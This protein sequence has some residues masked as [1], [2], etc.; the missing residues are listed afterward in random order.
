MAQAPALEPFRFTREQYDRMVDAGVLADLPVELLDGVIVEMTPQ[1]DEHV[2]VIQVLT[3]VLAPVAADFRLRV[4]GPVP[5]GQWSKPEPDL[6][7]VG[8]PG[9]AW[10]TADVVIEVVVTQRRQARV[11]ERIYAA[12]AIPE[13]WVVDVPARA[14]EVLTGPRPEGYGA[15]RTLTGDDRLEVPA[16]D[17]ATTVAEVLARAGLG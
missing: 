2:A 11:K 7:I 17:T 6:A 15:R 16:Y 1:G 8:L 14:V 5:A 3:G 4:Q 10:T 13:L 9:G 12:A